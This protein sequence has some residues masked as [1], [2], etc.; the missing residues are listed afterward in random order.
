MQHPAPVCNQLRR[1]IAIWGKKRFF[2]TVVGGGGGI[3]CRRLRPQRLYFFLNA[4]PHIFL[5]HPT[6]RCIGGLPKW[7]ES[8]QNFMARVATLAL[9][10]Y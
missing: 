7:Y 9:P 2:L 3:G 8:L 6:L 4:L 1:P 10:T 5:F